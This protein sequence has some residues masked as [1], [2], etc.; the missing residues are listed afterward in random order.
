[1]FRNFT[2]PANDI[3]SESPRSVDGSPDRTCTDGINRD[4]RSIKASSE[5]Y[6]SENIASR[7]KPPQFIEDTDLSGINFLSF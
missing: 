4:K 2:T 3:F 1:M 6:R 7:Q 5:P